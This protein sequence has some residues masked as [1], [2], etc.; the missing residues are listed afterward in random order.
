MA[1]PARPDRDPQ[2]RVRSL[3]LAAGMT[4]AQLAERAGVS[5]QLVGTVEAGRHLPRVDAGLAL[6]AALDTDAGWLFGSHT[7]LLD[8]MSGL[9]PADG[10]LVR[11]GWVGEQMVTAPARIGSDGWHPADAVIEDGRAHRLGPAQSGVVVA[12]CEPGL[13]TLE[14][15][16]R[17]GGVGAVA[18][19]ASSAGALAALIGGRVHAAVVHG[20]P[21][22]LPA[23]PDGLDVDRIRLTRWRV[24]V[25]LPPDVDASW[26]QQVLDGAMPV[27][28]REDGATVQ[29]AFEEALAGSGPVPGPRVGGHVVAARH[30]SA[31]GIPAVTIEPAAL[32]MGVGFHALDHHEA[33]LWISR[34]WIVDRG[35]EQLLTAINGSHFRRRLQAIGGY[36]LEGTGSRL[37]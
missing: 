32:A 24:G 27:V 9:T 12:G 11:L 35:V 20:P 28:Q 15:L 8:V 34:R 3:R 16:L 30:G 2:N 21:D 26:W 33:Q 37:P 10:A 29:R 31:A 7:P 25:S 4:Q 36:D 17:Q 5:R 19:S 22:S 23:V 13:E 18:V 1:S 14:H 6:A